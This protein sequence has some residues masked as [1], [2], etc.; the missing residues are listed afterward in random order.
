M[1]WKAFR[2]KILIEPI[3]AEQ[4]IGG[5]YIPD[6]SSTLKKGIV[7]T[8][9]EGDGSPMTVKEGETVLFDIEGS[10][11]ITLDSKQY[12]LIRERDVWMIK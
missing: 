7:I 6:T 5:L 1:D 8:V 12:R 11:P 3:S 9:G 2:D 10:T 4:T